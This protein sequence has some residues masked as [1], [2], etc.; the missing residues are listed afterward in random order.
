MKCGIRYRSNNANRGMPTGIVQLPSQREEW[1]K[2]DIECRLKWR[3]ANAHRGVY[4][5]LIAG[6][7][8]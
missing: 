7:K 4:G 1:G 8:R 3:S 5:V 2:G 6:V